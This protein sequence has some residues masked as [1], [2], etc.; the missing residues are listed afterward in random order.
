MRVARSLRRPRLRPQ[1]RAPASGSW[2]E[3]RPQ[4]IELLKRLEGAQGCRVDLLELFAQR[5]GGHLDGQTELQLGRL[6][7]TLLFELAQ[8]LA[9]ARDDCG[10]KARYCGE[11][12]AI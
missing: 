2:G 12:N 11:V 9:C 7:R 1:L 10:G 6:E 3:L 4:L 8:H 5:I